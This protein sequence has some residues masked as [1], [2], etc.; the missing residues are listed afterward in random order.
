M[1]S[2][3]VILCSYNQEHCIAQAIESI[4]NQKVEANV[5]V[6]IADDSSTDSTLKII[7]GYEEKSA[8][9]FLYLTADKNLGMRA[10]YKRA[11]AACESDYVAILEGDDWW[12]KD[13]HLAQHVDFL[14]HHKRYSMSYNLFKIYKQ[15][16]QIV[17]DQRWLYKDVQ[18]LTITLRQ[19][20]SWGNQI[21]NLSA[22]VFRTELLHALP[23]KFFQLNYADWE[24][25]IMMALNGPIAMLREVTSTYRIYN[26]GQWS[27]L[28]RDKRIASMEH[29]L[30]E[31]EPLLPFYCKSYIYSYGRRLRKGE[32]PPF[33]MPL[34]NRLKGIAKKGLSTLKY[35][36]R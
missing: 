30:A 22:C 9:P 12:H 29:S 33:P 32:R 2:I 36:K 34:K 27:A 11:F 28:T 20:I 23:E 21:G 24:L 19:Q 15:D 31:I 10:N 5:R 8:F 3:D 7:K 17:R 1:V 14:E 16:Q 35:R 4:L 26:K 6:I 25:G 13:N 18:Y